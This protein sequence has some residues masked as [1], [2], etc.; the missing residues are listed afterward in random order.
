MQSS[1]RNRLLCA[2]PNADL[3]HLEA[4]LTAVQ[5]PVRTQLQASLTSVE[6]VYF[7]ESGIA[8][9]VGT[10]AGHDTEVGVIGH[11]G[12]S[13]LCILHGADR[14]PYRVFMQVE[15]AGYRLASHVLTETMEKSASC[16]RLMM[17]FAQAFAIQ[18]AETAIAN[19]R[20]SI[21]ERL[22]RW[23]LMAQDRVE[24][25]AVPLTH[26][27]LSVM[28]GI[29]RAGVTQACHELARL[30]LI[31]NTRGLI[32]VTDP[33]GLQRIASDF[34]GVPE[35]ELAR[36]LK[37]AGSLVPQENYIGSAELTP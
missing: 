13:S 25:R 4:Y 36:L 3:R 8:S 26:E 14:S 29:R 21:L 6:H 33:K 28:L 34:Y 18:T 24:S 30:G 5:L 10:V 20:G 7:F 35:R 12:V 9:V 32:V 23:L 15:G 2:L 37:N 16:R 27:F 22:A 17:A 11:E 1:Y 31:D 19:A